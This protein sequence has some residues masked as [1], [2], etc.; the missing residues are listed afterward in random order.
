MKWLEI[1]Y[2]A[3]E[4]NHELVSQIF[5]DAGSKGVLL[6]DSKTPHEIPKDRF[7]EVYRLDVADYP[8]DGVIVKGYLA[9]TTQVEVLLAEIKTRLFE[10]AP[11]EAASFSVT[12]LEEEDWAESWK[13]YYEPV[14]ISERLLIKPSWLEPSDDANVVEIRLDP[15]MAFGSGTHETTRLCLQL[16]EKYVNNTSQVVD[17]G[18][19]SGILAIASAKLGAKSVYGVDLDE[20]A[21]IRAR[22]NVA[23]NDCSVILEI[24]NL[25]NGGATLAWKPNLIVANILASIIVGMLED[26]VRVLNEGDVFICSGIIVEE[27]E[28]VIEA[29]NAHQ[30]TVIE[31]Y[32]ENGWLAIVSRKNVE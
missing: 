31:I 3:T 29:L 16:L 24:N 1:S 2:H 12:T 10:L 27:K 25:M 17:V 28:M 30:F 11:A 14:W 20:M 26:V 21:V 7:G 8:S 23:L 13:A 6:E 15:G 9:V 5:I 4:E 18:T 19:G 22:E 32:E